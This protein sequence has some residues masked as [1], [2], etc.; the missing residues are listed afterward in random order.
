LSSGDAKFASGDTQSDP[1]EAYMRSSVLTAFVEAA[2]ELDL[3]PYRLLRKAGVPDATLEH[4]DLKVSARRVADLIDASAE[5][6]GREDIGLRVGGAFRLSMKGPLGLLLREQATV[7]KSLDALAHY[8]RYQ[9]TTVELIVTDRGGGKSME[10]G[11]L[12]DAFRSSVQSVD[13][14]V[15]M[16]VQTLR[17]LLGDSWMPAAVRMVRPPPA[18]PTAFR[19]QLGAVAFAQG[20]NA[21]DLSARDIAAS[22]PG[23]DA[24]LARELARYIER[25]VSHAGRSTTERVSELIVRLLPTGHCTIDELAGHL[26][27]DRRTIHRRLAGEGKSFTQLVE[28]VRR[29]VVTTQLRSDD[30]S[31]GDLAG[32]L[33]F[34][35]LSTFSRWFRHTYG[36]RASE[37][38][39]LARG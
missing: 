6:S 33:G 20:V 25:G 37:F 36:I 22:I 5:Q 1:G 34:S 23:A 35:S 26:G 9:N 7:G 21:I 8:I 10:I 30:T 13:M 14:T 27:V 16:Y 29:Q 3:E 32:R 31:L 24:D 11:L 28:E 12:S 2:R 4:G 15:A 18:D 19:D 39:Q 38:R 17:G